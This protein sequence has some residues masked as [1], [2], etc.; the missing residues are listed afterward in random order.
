MKPLFILPDRIN[1]DCDFQKQELMYEEEFDLP[2]EVLKL[3]RESAITLLKMIIPN[4]Q[5]VETKKGLKFTV[6]GA[7]RPL[8][9]GFILGEFLYHV[10]PGTVNQI[11]R[12]EVDIAETKD[13]LRIKQWLSGWQKEYSEAAKSI[14]KLLKMKEE[15]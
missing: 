3:T 1:I 5:I 2:K 6:V 10:P 13:L 9:A 4:V 8:I 15:S 12:I 14:D 11:P 7:P